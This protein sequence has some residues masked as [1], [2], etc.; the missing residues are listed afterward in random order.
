[1]VFA[2]DFSGALREPGREDFPSYMSQDETKVG[3]ETFPAV[4][5]GSKEKTMSHPWI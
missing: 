2:F 4:P 1:M 3:R 5:T